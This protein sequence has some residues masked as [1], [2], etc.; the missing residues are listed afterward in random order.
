MAL[1]LAMSLIDA[2]IVANRPATFQVNITNTS[3]SSVTLSS[4]AVSEATESECTIGQPNFLTP[5]V[6]MGLGNPTI[7]ASSTVSYTFKASFQSPATPGASPSTPGGNA[8]AYAGQPADAVFVLRAEAQA[9][10]GSVGSTTIQAVV[11][12]SIAP[13]PPV[14]TGTLQLQFQPGF[15]AIGGLVLGLL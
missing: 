1:T 15:N 11:L 4:L 7:G 10:D 14:A 6:A 9:S 12:T 2:T 8:G 13:F 5:Q 3:A